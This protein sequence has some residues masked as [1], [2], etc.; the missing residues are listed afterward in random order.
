MRSAVLVTGASRGFGR[1]LALDFARLLKTQDLELHLWARSESDLKE[2]ERLV[3]SEWGT[4][5][6]LRCFVQCVDLSNPADYAAKVDQ[7]LLQL[8]AQSYARVFL[9]HNAGSLGQLGLVHECASNPTELAQ[10]WELNVTSVL[11]LNKRFLDVFGASRDELLAATSAEEKTQL[12]IVNI[13]SL[14]GIEPF[15]THMMYCSGKAAREMHH[16]VIAT[17]QEAAGKV[18]VLQYSPGPMDTDMQ[19]TIRESPRV[20]P[21]LRKQFEDMKA[22]GTLIPPAQSSQRGVK[23]AISGDYETGAHV[24]YYDLDP[25]TK[26]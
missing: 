15:K 17:E 16:R 7:V 19:K 4:A 13:T 6:E 14:C 26:K 1:C 25:P 23:L 24:D 12:V 8:A 11:W 3:R 20:D 21:E 9:V 10:Y 22:Q 18:R 2:T 5:A